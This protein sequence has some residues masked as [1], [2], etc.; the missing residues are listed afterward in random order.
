MDSADVGAS[1][2]QSK[3]VQASGSGLALELTQARAKGS[4]LQSQQGHALWFL[5]SSTC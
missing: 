4:P 2:I 5:T 3:Y 1:L